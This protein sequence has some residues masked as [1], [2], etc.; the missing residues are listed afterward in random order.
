[1]RLLP[2]AYAVRNLGRSPSRLFL[3]V[4]GA[5]MV[6]LLILVAGGFVRGMSTALRA[7]GAIAG[8]WLSFAQCF[9]GP[10][11]PPPAPGTRFRQMR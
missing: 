8:Q 5:A 4:A 9:A 3:S 2:F 7:T 11:H 6:V 1:M 10:P